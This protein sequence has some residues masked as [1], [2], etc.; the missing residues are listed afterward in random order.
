MLNFFSSRYL[1]V[2]GQVPISGKGTDVSA[3]IIITIPLGTTT[4]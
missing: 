4:V 3:T 2:R 1:F